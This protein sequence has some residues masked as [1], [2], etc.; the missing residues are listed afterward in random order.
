MHTSVMLSSD[1]TRDTC[2]TIAT[3]SSD[4]IHGLFDPIDP[5]DCFNPQ[6]R[7]YLDLYAVKELQNGLRSRGHCAS[8]K[9]ADLI[10]RVLELTKGEG[11]ETCPEL[12]DDDSETV[13]ETFLHRSAV[14]CHDSSL[15]PQPQLQAI[16]ETAGHMICQI[17]FRP[18]E[19]KK[20]KKNDCNNDKEDLPKTI[21]ASLCSHCTAKTL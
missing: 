18:P 21:Q 8:R 20:S 1:L 13:I 9:K 11:T 15:E 16:Q 12:A 14:D 2:L 6:T 5:K 3:M 17:C 10:A 19:K 4:R 7:A